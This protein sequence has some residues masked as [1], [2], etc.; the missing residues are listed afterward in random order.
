MFCQRRHKSENNTNQ[1]HKK[2]QWIPMTT[3]DFHENNNF[4]RPNIYRTSPNNAAWTSNGHSFLRRALFNILSRVVPAA[5][6]H[7][8]NILY[9]TTTNN[10]RGDAV[11]LYVA[12]AKAS[13]HHDQTVAT[14]DNFL[15]KHATNASEAL[16]FVGGCTIFQA[17][18]MF[19]D[20]LA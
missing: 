12:S 8:S 5:Q 6:P 16:R 13:A 3:T 10:K 19:H 17:K 9:K 15:P 4:A 11:A 20:P 14:S 18:P 1:I 7:T 2:K